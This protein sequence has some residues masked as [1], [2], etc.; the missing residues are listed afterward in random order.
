MVAA[1]TPTLLDFH[2]TFEAS[3]ETHTLLSALSGSNL[4]LGSWNDRAKNSYVVKFLPE[5]HRTDIDAIIRA[6]DNGA[7]DDGESRTNEEH[8]VPQDLKRLCNLYHLRLEFIFD[9][10]TE[11]DTSTLKELLLHL[12]LLSTLR[13]SFDCL[14]FEDHRVVHR[15]PEFI[16]EKLH[17]GYLRDLSLQAMYTPNAKLRALMTRHAET[18]RSLELKHISFAAPGKLAEPYPGSLRPALYHKHLYHAILRLCDP[19]IAFG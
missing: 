18:L 15:L 8:C 12:P 14:S 19:H 6:V 5:D 3:V 2:E 16:S 7:E 10:V 4:V 13:V 1:S 11:G 9:E 17:W